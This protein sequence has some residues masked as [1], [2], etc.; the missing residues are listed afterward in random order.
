MRWPQGFWIIGFAPTVN[1]KKLQRTRGEEKTKGAT[2][3]DAAIVHSIGNSVSPGAAKICIMEAQLTDA[4]AA[5]PC[6]RATIHLGSETFFVQANNGVLSE[7]LVSVKEQS[8]GILKDFIMKH[9]I[10]TE[11]PDEPEEV[12]SEDDSE[13]SAKPPMKKSKN[14][15]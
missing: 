11:V 8:M 6:V 10:P 3:L 12:S 5:D 4:V 2:N 13:M 15:Q 7:Q 14:G 1:P 9:N